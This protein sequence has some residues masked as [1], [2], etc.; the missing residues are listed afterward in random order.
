MNELTVEGWAQLGGGGTPKS[1]AQ[2]RNRHNT[3]SLGCRASKSET[4]QVI[5]AR[6]IV[7]RSLNGLSQTD[8]ALKLGYQTSAQL[9]QWEQCK[10]MP[11]MTE[12]INA[13]RLY[14]V[15]LDFLVG[16][17]SDPDRDPTSAERQHLLTGA[18]QMMSHMAERL[19]DAVIYQT[20]LGGPTVEMARIVLRDGEQ[21]M[22]R[23][24]RFVRDNGIEY[25]SMKWNASLTAAASDLEE[26]L[27]RARQ[28][29]DRQRRINDAAMAGVVTQVRPHDNHP[30]FEEAAND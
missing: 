14:R 24:N 2:A 25:E 15:S 7:A 23:F 10:R 12:L 22:E 1:G 26:T 20:N 30:L 8:A 28:I 6:L 3:H 13:A 4:K 21:F 19:A 16:I 27:A 11:P 17:S 9:S 5:G 29:L 18:G